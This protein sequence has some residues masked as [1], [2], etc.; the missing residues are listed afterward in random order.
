MG[1]KIL[2]FL[3]AF[4][5]GALVSYAD[6]FVTKKMTTVKSSPKT[7]YLSYIFRLALNTVFLFAV[8]FVSPALPFG[9]WPLVLGAVFGIT[10][11]SAVFTIILARKNGGD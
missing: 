5:S 6:N 4:F 11:P 1:L 2:G 10:I 3:A 8:F 9:R 7:Y